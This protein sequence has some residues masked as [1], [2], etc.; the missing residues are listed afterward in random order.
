MSRLSRAGFVLAGGRSS[1][2]G[3]DK[4]MLPLGGE[5]MLARIAR[6]VENV[7]G[8]VAIL[9]PPD[10]YGAFG[11]PVIADQFA[12][13][14]PIAGI[15][16]ALSFTTAD[17]NLIV[18]CDMPDLTPDLL[19]ELFRAAA[20]SGADA[21]VP[22]SAAGLEPLCA[23]YH[24]RLAA[25]AARAIDRKIFKMHDFLSTLQLELVPVADAAP[26]KNINTHAQWIAR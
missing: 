7:A 8:S 18:A 3:R 16:S 1:R 11:Y 10:R 26:L 24:R 6:L 20:K 2:M 19:E 13:C 17:W 25:P 21:S 14:G 5:T 23:V 22:R 12:G 9:G 4:A 15:Y